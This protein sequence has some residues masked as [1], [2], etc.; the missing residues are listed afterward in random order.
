MKVWINI[1][2]NFCF[3]SIS[4]DTVSNVVS[5][6][7]ADAVIGANSHKAIEMIN[8]SNYLDDETRTFMRNRGWV[9]VESEF[10]QNGNVFSYCFE[11]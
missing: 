10:R 3:S 9:E 8:T 2:K 7:A 5:I 11:K 4:I 6:E 1:D